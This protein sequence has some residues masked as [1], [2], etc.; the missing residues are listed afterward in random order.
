MTDG[1]GRGRIVRILAAVMAVAAAAGAAWWRFHRSDGPLVVAVAHEEGLQSAAGSAWAGRVAA[2]CGCDIEWHDVTPDSVEGRNVNDLTTYGTSPELSDV[3]RPDV[4]IGWERISGRDRTAGAAG[5]RLVDLGRH[6]DDMP[7]VDEYF[8]T[9]PSAYE[10]A[11]EDDGSIRS[12]PGDA[13][14]EYDGSMAHLFVNRA[15]LDGLGLQ[16]PATWD[17][18]AGV[19]R[20]FRDHD[21]NGNG[22]A[23]EIPL[24][25]RPPYDEALDESRRIPDGWRLFL[26][27]T[28]IPTQLNEAPGDAGFA[29]ADGTVSSYARS[30]ELRHVATWLTGLAG[31]GLTPRGVFADAYAY[32][33]NQDA[34][35]EALNSGRDPADM[36]ALTGATVDPTG[37]IDDA[38][39][40]ELLA[41]DTPVVGVAFA[42]DA[43]A[44]GANADDYESIPMPAAYEGVETTWDRSARARFNLNGVAVRADTR[45]LDQA[46]AVVDALFDQTVSLGQY[47]GDHGVEVTH[48][49][50]PAVVDVT[51]PDAVDGYGRA[52][53]GWI[54]P[55]TR[56]TGDT[57]RDRYVAADAPYKPIYER[58]GDD[59]T[60]PLA[61]NAGLNDNGYMDPAQY[62][63][64]GGAD[65]QLAAQIYAAGPGYDADAAWQAWLD[66]TYADAAA[67]RLD[68]ATDLWQRR[69]DLYLDRPTT[70]PDSPPS[71]D[72]S[73][74]HRQRIYHDEY[75]KEERVEKDDR[76]RIPH[77]RRTTFR[78][79]VGSGGGDVAAID[80]RPDGGGV[81]GVARA[82]GRRAA[83]PRHVGH[84]VRVDGHERVDDVGRRP[85]GCGPSHG[86][87]VAATPPEMSEAGNGTR[88]RTAT[89]DPLTPPTGNG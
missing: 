27:A 16:V 55:G 71:I 49:D 84:G 50:G 81:R 33:L 9:V 2:L 23:D 48:E 64:L 59:G 29:V 56:I 63:N 53:V 62:D 86:I 88:P 10:A 66:D 72:P 8:R 89:H 74:A 11:M 83:N 20:A 31:E 26:N 21:P 69:Y 19:L 7:N 61:I 30:D 4:F 13:G 85:S 14:E 60:F 3:A 37:A 54:R 70:V 52:F 44:F 75:I 77:P 73:G 76:R 5:G 17:E 82:A 18:L 35:S 15:W 87:R 41:Q 46:L 25:L 6:L 80:G 28:G 34:M 68:D 38:R 32:K 79:S 24:L 47:Y 45:R 42:F 51:D 1:H 78:P 22:Q 58:T 12:I 40:R 43:S 67:Q 57:D 65:R 36:T 39:Y